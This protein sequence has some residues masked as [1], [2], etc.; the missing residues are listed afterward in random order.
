MSNFLSNLVTR[1]LGTATV[2]RPRL[3]SFFEPATPYALS[4]AATPPARDPAARDRDRGEVFDDAEQIPAAQ[5]RPASAS[6][7]RGETNAGPGSPPAAV[8]PPLANE[9]AREAARRRLAA[10]PALRFEGTS[11]EADTAVLPAVAH[12]SSSEENGWRS[13]PS[14]ESAGD[15]QGS[16]R[17]AAYNAPRRRLPADGLLTPVVRDRSTLHPPAPAMLRTHLQTM[18]ENPE[19]ASSSLPEAKTDGAHR[20]LEAAEAHTKSAPVEP[21]RTRIRDAAP[22]TTTA[23]ESS[24]TRRFE[25]ARQIPPP[26]LASPPEPTIQVTIGRVEVRAVSEQASKAKE[27]AASPVMSLNDYLGLRSKRGGA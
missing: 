17:D 20:F 12:A 10:V 4:L 3:P 24:A 14:A 7:G 11:R 9:P 26:P 25:L 1:S 2:V 23:I 15:E 5:E 8:Q 13:A 21:T 18:K 27:R 6:K 19:R 22:R 16:E